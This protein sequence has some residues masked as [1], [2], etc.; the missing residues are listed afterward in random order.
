MAEIS[1]ELRVLVTAEV[2]KAVRDLKKVDT[3]T[4]QTEQSFKLLGKTI[5]AA[6]VAGAIV[7]FA[8]EADAAYREHN[9]TV[10]ILKSTLK[11]TGAE[12]WTT[13]Q[14]LQNM[15]GELQSAT[16]YTADSIN[17]MQSV[18][19]G[20]KNISGDTFGEATKAILD[21]AT[22]MDMDLSSAAQSIG[23]A[24]D[25]PINGMDSLK[26]QGFN[27]TAAQKK[28][29]QSLLDTG[30][31]AKAQ[32]IILDEL[33]GTFGGA[34]EAAAD[35]ATQIKNAWSDILQAYGQG[36]AEAFESLFKG[37][38]GKN[39]VAE[40]MEKFAEWVKTG[41]DDW[42]RV[43]NFDDWYAGMSD[44]EKLEEASK[45]LDIWTQKYEQALN[46]W[47]PGAKKRREDAKKNVDAWKEAVNYLEQQIQEEK[48]IISQE[49]ERAETESKINDLMLEISKSYDKLAS[50]EPTVQ[51]EKYNKQLED[52]K[53]KR[54][55][56]SK[57]VSD[58]D[59]KLIDTTEALKQLDVLEKNIKKKIEN[60]E[61]DGKK[62]WKK[63]LSE[64]LG[65]DTKL[66]NKGKEAATLYINGLEQTLTNAEGISKALGEKVFGK[67]DFLD[68][69]LEDLKSK[70]T[71]ALTID[72]SKITESFSLEELADENT[73]LG[74]LI[75]KYKELKQ[76][77][78]ES[79][80]TDKLRELEKEVENLGKSETE[81]YLSKLKEAGATEQQIEQAKE[82]LKTI[83]EYK[84]VGDI[85]D[86][87]S[88]K[89]K[90]ALLNTGKFSEKSAETLS[91]LASSL[92]QVSVTATVNG[93]KELGKALGEGDNAA[94]SMEQALASM[95]QEILNQLPLL[96]MQAGLQLIAQGQWPLGLG[97]IAGG[98][99]DGV[100]AGYVQGK[101]SSTKANA[102]GGVYGA[103]D[104]AAFAK[105]GTFTNQI[106]S[107]PTYFRFAKGSGFG[108]GLMGEA[109][110]E[111]IMPLTRGADGALGIRADGMGGGVEVN[112][113]VTVYSDEPVEVHDTEDD[114][115]QRKIEILVGSMIN[116]HIAGGMAD[117]A[118]KSRYGL[119]VQGV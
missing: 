94:E 11:A 64:I 12:A 86:L 110:P 18:L 16:N 66:F 97:L 85:Y 21:M 48:Q 98:L 27:F 56:L 61:I 72:P 53:K 13:S 80:V 76:A 8:K 4:K 107:S 103:E 67:T 42:H 106:V 36:Y 46:S 20:F 23:K 109:G 26:K 117:R 47:G 77:R 57:P 7:K 92:A 55:E 91:S 17:K 2:E 22:V 63:W 111:A 3:Q 65:V 70:I 83:S 75:Q 59:G 93:M 51:L 49:N 24:L 29:I 101:T 82:Y 19:L 38:D 32:K 112:I 25:D 60:L 87:I 115:G 28:V 39:K 14:E 54:A 113:P 102:L 52:I 50:D 105:G 88:V 37:K 68:S 116:Q 108:T 9:Q 114:S 96:M 74:T 5:S 10:N 15:A 104:Y 81:L 79:Y 41:F 119:K 31:T 84:E 40:G 44:T 95:A 71:E 100:V 62:S 89:I 33:N 1:D 118:M 6:F 78:N 43:L 73:A 30:E 45:Q 34:A 99:I 35:S 69:Q 90:D 58:S